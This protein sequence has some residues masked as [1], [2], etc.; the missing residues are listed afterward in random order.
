MASR[1]IPYCDT[2]A[3]KKL[4]GCFVYFLS[5][6]MPNIRSFHLRTTRSYFCSSTSSS[7][8]RSS[9]SLSDILSLAL[10]VMRAFLSFSWIPSWRERSL[11]SSWAFLRGSASFRFSCCTVF[12]VCSL[13]SSFSSLACS[14][15]ERIDESTL[16]SRQSN[17]ID[18]RPFLFR[19]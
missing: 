16:H 7:H 9:R 4:D 6:P 3:R 5:H 17:V 19:S 13:R 10:E 15:V 14:S 11:R 12:K 18:I 1:I 8:L 2:N